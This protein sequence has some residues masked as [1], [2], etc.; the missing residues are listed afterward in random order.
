MIMA[1][2]IVAKTKIDCSDLMGKFVD[3]SHY[4]VLVEE[5]T[6]CYL[7][8]DCDIT[9]RASSTETDFSDSEN[10]KDEK[11]IGFI[12]RKN[13]FTKEEQEQ[14]Y[15]GLRGAAT[16]TQNRGMA[17]GP[18]GAKLGG[19][20]W[21][22]VEQI[23]TLTYLCELSEN[24]ISDD[25][26][27]SLNTI[28]GL[29]E[30]KEDTRGLV[31]LSSEVEKH[32]FNYEEWLKAVIKKPTVEIKKEAKWVL[33]TFI[34]DTT[35]A[36]AVLSG[37]AG[38]FDRYPR[39][40][41][42]RATSYTRDN[43]DKFKMAFP[44][45]QS[46][47]RGFRE[48]LPWRWSNQKAAADKI[49]SR[50]LVPGTVFT[51]VTVNSNFRTAAHYDAGDLNAGLSNLLV[52]SNGGRYKGGYLVLPEYRVAVNVRP[53]DLLLINNHECMHGNTPIELEDEDAERISLVCYFRE[54][55]LELGSYEYENT[56]YQYVE[57]RRKN[58]EHR[59]WKPLWNGISEGMWTEEEWYD[60]LREHGGQEMLDKYHLNQINKNKGSSLEGLFA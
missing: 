45:L 22:T 26:E 8:A 12:F 57:S 53:G 14:A 5:D 43:F 39:I 31:W 24:S 58:R 52:V 4:D 29:A 30:K 51:T 34:S 6:D 50:F 60:Y 25:L 7:P 18:K 35:Y 16:A 36:N 55:M 40:P 21:A 37:V 13:W 38:W 17:A 1:K 19:R 3:E 42:G 41:Y 47:D 27:S 59:L 10:I 49:D 2:V 46:L 23:D 56:R 32:E 9:S 44:F 20:D 54:K 48:L 28:R 11:R 33:E 15:I